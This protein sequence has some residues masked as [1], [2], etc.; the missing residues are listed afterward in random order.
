VMTANPDDAGKLNLG[1]D[2][3]HATLITCV[4]IGTANSRLFV[5]GDQ[6]SPDPST[7]KKPGD[8]GSGQG[9]APQLTGKEPTVL[10][11]LFGAGSN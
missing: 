8:N 7:A 2:K 10:E 5:V 11:R 1:Y 9:N 4:P 3:P 6:I